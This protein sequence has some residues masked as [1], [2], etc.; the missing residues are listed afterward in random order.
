MLTASR[1]NGMDIVDLVVQLQAELERPRVMRGCDLA[2]VAVREGVADIVKLRVVPNVEEL[3]PELQ[4][5]AALVEGERLEERQIPVIA[6]RTTHT[7]EGHIAP[8]AG[9]RGRES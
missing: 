1:A 9:Q 6:A 5:A 2:E 4:T 8:V 3:R 7:I